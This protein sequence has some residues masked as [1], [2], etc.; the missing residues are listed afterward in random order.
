M[1]KYYRLPTI[2]K[3]V[4]GYQQRTFHVKFLNPESEGDNGKQTRFIVH[5][6]N[7][8]KDL[9]ILLLHIWALTNYLIYWKTLTMTLIYILN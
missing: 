6:P 1:L 9:Y 5:V 3:R 2:H 4:N 8:G 7:D